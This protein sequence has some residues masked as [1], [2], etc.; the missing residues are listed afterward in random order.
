MTLDVIRP[1]LRPSPLAPVP[2]QAFTQW[3]TDVYARLQAGTPVRLQDCLDQ[4]RQLLTHMLPLTTPT[5]LDHRHSSL[6][7][8]QLLLEQ[9]PAIC[10]PVAAMP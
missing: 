8:W 3:A 1:I 4:G 2:Y 10:S 6:L 9:H 5:T 7:N